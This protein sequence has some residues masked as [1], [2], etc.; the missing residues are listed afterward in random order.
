[1][2]YIVFQREEFIEI[3]E[4]EIKKQRQK[5]LFSAA[6]IYLSG[7]RGSGKSSFL[8]L[9][10]K[11]FKNLGFKTYFIPDGESLNDITSDEIDISLAKNDKVAILIDEI[12][13]NPNSKLWIFMFKMCKNPNLIVVG[14]AVPTFGV[15]DRMTARFD[16]SFT[17]SS[18]L[19]EVGNS[20]MK[21]LVSHWQ[22]YCKTNSTYRKISFDLV[23]K[24]RNLNLSIIL[25]ILLTSENCSEG[26]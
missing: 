6:S 18:L 16:T 26:G 15:L 7:S 13:T 21:Q 5:N 17:M 1:M 9:L 8:M 11:K 10:C 3:V 2:G 23:E 12:Y 4:N 24:I 20:D 22:N 19:L 25:I 14:A